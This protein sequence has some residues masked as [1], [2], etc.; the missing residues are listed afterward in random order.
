MIVAV[1]PVV[2]PAAEFT[3]RGEHIAIQH[4]GVEGAVEAFDANI[5]VWACRVGM[6]QLDAV[7]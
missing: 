7:V 5:F 2:G 4:L 1:T 3:E 6:H